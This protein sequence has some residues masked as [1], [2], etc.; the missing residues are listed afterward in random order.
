M[1]SIDIPGQMEGYDLRKTKTKNKNE[2]EKRY[3]ENLNDLELGFLEGN[4]VQVQ[5]PYK[6]HADLMRILHNA[7][8]VSPKLDS[9]ILH[10]LEKRAC[11]AEFKTNLIE[12][13]YEADGLADKSCR[14]L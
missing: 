13:G 14:E 1:G 10:I 3:M 11:E 4:H 2:E 5:D 9:L 12:V 8:Y 7:G 6:T